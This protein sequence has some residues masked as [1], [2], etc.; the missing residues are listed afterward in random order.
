M[1]LRKG[2]IVWWLLPAIMLLVIA[3]A[4]EAQS[5]AAAAARG[6]QAA[7][8]GFSNETEI[9]DKFN[10]WAHD[11]DA[12]RWLTA[13]GYRLDAVRSVAAVKPHGEKSDVEV[14][15]KTDDDEKTEGISI[16]LVSSPNGFNQID[17]RWLSHYAAM[18]RMPASVRD[19]LKLFV[20][21]VP[22]VRPGRAA[23]RMFLNELDPAQQNA[24]IAF[25]KANRAEIVADLFQ[26]DGEHS[27]AWFMVAFK[28]TSDTRWTL[29][30]IK[31]A[32]KFYGEG[33]V[34]ITRNGNLKI[35]RVTM[36]RKGGDA[37]RETA[38]MLQFK[39]NPVELFDFAK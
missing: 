6:S 22:P 20:G 9:R 26:G 7:K 8:A 10:K 31:D 21:E 30:P 36:Q 33:P 1:N 14:R 13:M 35:G 38:K 25:F 18:W 4:G 17:K 24:V 11:A 3:A 39:I 15:V 32:I 28:S 29:C 12:R 2:W 23:N 19:A 5:S 16:K 34:V 37:G 27:A